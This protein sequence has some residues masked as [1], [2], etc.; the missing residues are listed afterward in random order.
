MVTVVIPTR[1]R[2]ALL[3][4]VLRSVQA[5]RGISF[6]I[7]VVDDHSIDE[8]SE[9]IA[10]LGDDRI[11]VLR[12]ERPG[13]AAAARNLGMGEAA[14]RWIAFLDDD[15][16]WAPDK[17]AR[18]LEAMSGSGR[19]W[20]Y[21]GAVFI[22]PA[23]RI[24]GGAPPPSPDEVV[25]LLPRYNPIPAAASNVIVAT[26]VIAEIGGFDPSLTHMTDWDLWLRIA[27]RW[28][29]PACEP[30]PSVAYRL[31][32]GNFSARSA[33]IRKEVT[34]MKL[35]H[36]TVDSTRIYRHMSGLAVGSGR[37]VDGLRLLWSAMR[38][39]D[40]YALDEM[41]QDGRKL[42]RTALDV[43][44][45]RLGRDPDQVAGHRNY[46]LVRRDPNRLYKN[47]A[48]AW[49]DDINASGNHF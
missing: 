29:P 2:I 13:G 27:A 20:A 30:A 44:G 6:E 10:S 26:E 33:G 15:D 39:P 41:M 37:W 4:R 1:N 19:L 34:T 47:E 8:T 17:L 38:G 21:S 25:A 40:R 5:Q 46:R 49:L 14:G 43:A 24:R 42:L 11:R 9:V 23:G 48:R 35:R 18:Q 32:G 12:T 45:R 28:G 36:P 3:T 31:H 7:I 16:L 22:N